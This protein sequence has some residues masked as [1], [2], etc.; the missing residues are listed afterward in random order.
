MCSLEHG[1]QTLRGNR[2]PETQSNTLYEHSNSIHCFF[3][4]FFIFFFASMLCL[5]CYVLTSSLIT[6]S[7]S[8]LLELSGT[9]RMNSGYTSCALNLKPN[10][11]T[12]RAGNPKRLKAFLCFL[13][14]PSH[15]RRPFALSVVIYDNV[16]GPVGFVRYTTYSRGS[17]RSRSS[18]SKATSTDTELLGL[19]QAYNAR[20]KPSR[21]SRCT[22]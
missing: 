17:C 21:C 4:S 22:T 7:P 2:T 9:R 6:I 12:A 11:F 8:I 1:V 16:V 19:L 13:P 20:A 15:R 14:C 10:G 18:S 5:M 3:F